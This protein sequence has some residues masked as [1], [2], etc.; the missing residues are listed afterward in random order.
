MSIYTEV[1]VYCKPISNSTVHVNC[2]ESERKLRL[3]YNMRTLYHA[4][5]SF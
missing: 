2:Y 3:Q 1:I 4:D 5:K